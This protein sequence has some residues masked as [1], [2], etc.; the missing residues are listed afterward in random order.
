LLLGWRKAGWAKVGR[1]IE[2][3][4]RGAG[5]AEKMAQEAWKEKKVCFY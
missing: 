5:P 1:K 3:K 4:R 2:K